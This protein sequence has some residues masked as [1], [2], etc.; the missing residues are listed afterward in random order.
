MSIPLAVKYAKNADEMFAAES[1]ISLLTNRDYDFNGAHTVI[2]YKMSTVPMNNYARNVGLNDN[3]D[4]QLSRFGRLVDLGASTEEL[5]LKRDRS[6]I[7]NVDILDQE[8]SGDVIEAAAALARELREV[9]IPEVDAYTYGVMVEKAGTKA[10]V[11]A[12]TKDNIYTA[13][14]AGSEALDNAEVPDTE[15]VLVLTPA[16]Y[17]LLKQSTVF[18]NTEVGADLR[19]KGVVGIL[20][21][22]NVVRV[23]A[24]RLP[25]GFGFLIAHPSATVAPVK[26]EDYNVHTDTVLSSGS[27][28]TGRICYDA[29]VLDNKAKG[30][31]YHPIA[32]KKVEQDTK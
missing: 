3:T 15:R 19:M 14:L 26:L 28:V 22:M 18:D 21:G 11:Q 27:I 8:E 2:I 4:A 6:F 12:L 17:T 31:Y 20:D 7:F 25:E 24:S 30:I 5:L 16:V 23:P 32:E 1:K 10:S 29:F 9:V 13:I